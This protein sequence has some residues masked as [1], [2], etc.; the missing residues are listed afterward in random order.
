M[1]VQSREGYAFLAPPPVLLT[2]SK[3]KKWITIP[4][5]ESNRWCQPSRTRPRLFLSPY[6]GSLGSSSPRSMAVTSVVAPSPSIPFIFAPYLGFRP[7]SPPNP[8]FHSPLNPSPGCHQSRREAVRFQRRFGDVACDSS[9]ERRQDS[10]KDEKVNA[11]GVR[12]FYETL[13]G[14]EWD[15]MDGYIY[16][17]LPAGAWPPTGA[18]RTPPSELAATTASDIIIEVLMTD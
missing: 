12:E 9:L 18:P 14:P 6:L 15:Q 10:E 7:P 17:C 3:S 8:V 5:H 11:L 1:S 16:V 2:S 4:P 13:W